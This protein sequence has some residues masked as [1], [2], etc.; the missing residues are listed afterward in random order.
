MPDT[1]RSKARTRVARRAKPWPELT[2][3]DIMERRVVTVAPTSPLSEVERLLTEHRI[4]GMPVTDTS[5]KA[6]GV[7][8]YRDLLDHYAENPD[9]R[10]RRGAGFFRLSTEHMLDEDFEAFEVPPESEDTVGDVMTP[11]IVDVSADA[12]IPEICRTMSRNSVH[13]VLVTDAATGRMTGIVSSLGVLA[14]IA[15]D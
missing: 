7:V 8:S 2:A 9:A 15:G 1:T 6:I 13:R 11:A 5:G 3:R 14:A 10:P 12:S 4:S